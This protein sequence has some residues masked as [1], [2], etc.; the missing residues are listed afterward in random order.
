MNAEKIGG[1]M[2]KKGLL[3][4]VA[5]LI[6]AALTW[7]YNLGL[8]V[9]DNETRINEMDL[10]FMKLSEQYERFDESMIKIIHKQDLRLTVMEK[11]LIEGFNKEK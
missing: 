1:D 10:K 9:Q 11:Y 2:I 7:G 6:V 3:G 8:N 4:G 5:T